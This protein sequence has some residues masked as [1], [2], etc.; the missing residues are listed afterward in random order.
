MSQPFKSPTLE[1]HLT[2][3]NQA[4]CKT[5]EVLR[6]AADLQL[7]SHFKPYQIG[8]KVW[9]KGCNLTT[10]HP[11]AKLAPRCYGPFLVTHFISHTSY[12]LKLPPQWKVHNV[13]HATLL[14]PY[15]ETALNGSHYQEPALELVEGQPEW[16]VEH[17]MRVRRCNQLQYLVRWKGFSDTHDSWEPANHLHTDQLIQDFYK[18]H[19]LAV[20]NPSPHTITIRRTTMSSPNSPVIQPTEVPALVYPLSPQPLMAPPRLE[21]HL[22]NPLVPLTLEE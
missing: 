1:Q 20:G 22:E 14:T 16:E 6:K 11:T 17:I 13:F 3:L 15:K 2:N 8:D 12:Q 21:D 4:K 9:L 10:T 19:P 5:A 18:E 7:P